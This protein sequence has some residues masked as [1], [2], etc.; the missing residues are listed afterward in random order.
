MYLGLP[1]LSPASFN[2]HKKYFMFLDLSAVAAKTNAQDDDIHH[3]DKKARWK[4]LCSGRWLDATSGQSSSRQLFKQQQQ[5]QQ[6]HQTTK[7]K[8]KLAS[9]YSG[10]V[11]TMAS[12]IGVISRGVATTNAVVP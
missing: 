12:S 9:A 4:Y 11:Q 1:A 2:L 5:Q 10:E 3:N 7:K 6:Q 8:K